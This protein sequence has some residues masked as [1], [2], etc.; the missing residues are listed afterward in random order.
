MKDW[1]N[2]TLSIDKMNEFLMKFKEYNFKLFLE[3]AKTGNLEE[4]RL[5]CNALDKNGYVTSYF[6]ENYK[7]VY[8][9]KDACNE[10]VSTVLGEL[11][12]IYNMFEN[13]KKHE[14]WD[15]NE[16]YKLFGFDF[17][18]YAEGKLLKSALTFFIKYLNKPLL[19]DEVPNV[20]YLYSH[21]LHW[22]LI[23]ELDSLNIDWQHNY[24]EFKKLN[25]SRKEHV[26]AWIVFTNLIWN[27]EFD[28]AYDYMYN[29]AI[30]H[31]GRVG[32]DYL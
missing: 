20:N 25:Q 3:I 19:L 5:L 24:S 18:P 13:S 12:P 32:W 26:E 30:R 15:R 6:S 9:L 27:N 7:E 4:F 8:T 22:D 28:K 14:F 16:R 10:R 11:L 29:L 17:P 31:N 1:Y 23:K 21:G 2:W